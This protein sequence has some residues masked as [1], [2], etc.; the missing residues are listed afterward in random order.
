[1][2]RPGPPAACGPQ[3]PGGTTRPHVPLA[4]PGRQAQREPEPPPARDT[5]AARQPGTGCAP[6]PSP[7][8][9][10]RTIL[11]TRPPGAGS[12]ETVMCGIFGYVGRREAEPILVEGLQ[13][14]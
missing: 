9:V 1:M 10:T 4:V 3:H 5:R 2:T 7:S 12:K 11:D 6:R 8:A 14:L 13:R